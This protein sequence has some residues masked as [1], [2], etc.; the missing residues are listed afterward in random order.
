MYVNKNTGP[1]RGADSN[2]D[3]EGCRISEDYKST[4]LITLGGGSTS[5]FILNF[6]SLES[7]DLVL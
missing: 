1:G 2:L 6:R 3:D 7:G 5:E 4:L